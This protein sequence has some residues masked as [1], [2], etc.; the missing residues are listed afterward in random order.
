MSR[1]KFS[2][3]L[4]QSICKGHSE[5]SREA[6]G[7]QGRDDSHMRERVMPAQDYLHS[8][9]SRSCLLAHAKKNLW[10]HTPLL[11]TRCDQHAHEP[12][13]HRLLEGI[14]NSKPHWHCAP[15]T[16]GMLYSEAGCQPF[17]SLRLKAAVPVTPTGTVFSSLQTQP[18]TPKQQTAPVFPYLNLR[19]QV[20][21]KLLVSKEVQRD[22]HSYPPG[23]FP[24]LGS[25]METFK[26]PGLRIRASFLVS[27]A[28]F[29]LL[30]LK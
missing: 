11:R 28:S 24:L 13:D 21:M 17:P 30:A 8:L 18:L 6:A 22:S 7:S 4:I 15:S 9:V 26:Q 10:G 16:L 19:L 12:R 23:T 27:L 2:S 3:V 5:P 25:R 29:L 14:G 20:R 1:L